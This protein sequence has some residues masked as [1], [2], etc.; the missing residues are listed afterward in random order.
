MKNAKQET[1]SA[2]LFL[3]HIWKCLEYIS[4]SKKAFQNITEREL[5][6]F[7]GVSFLKLHL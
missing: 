2:A 5:Q 1:T 3:L 4:P 6:N 7:Y